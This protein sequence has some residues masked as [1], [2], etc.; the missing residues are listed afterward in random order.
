MKTKCPFYVGAVLSLMIVSAALMGVLWLPVAF[1]YLSA[2]LSG[3]ALF[4]FA[5]LCG[6][7]GAVFFGILLS[8]SVFPKSMA[9]DSIF[10]RKT[11]KQIKG[12]SVAIFS[13]SLLLCVAAVWLIVVGERLI[14]P[15][16]LFVAL[17]G[18]MVASAVFILSDYIARAA[19]LKEEADLT[20]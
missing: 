13:D 18:I 2:F 4:A 3:G 5:I 20:L 9:E 17:I 19:V 7:I 1:A 8:A 10:T 15:A 16:M 12:I 6:V 11:A 14:M